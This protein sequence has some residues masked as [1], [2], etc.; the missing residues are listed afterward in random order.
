MANDLRLSMGVPILTAIRATATSSARR[1][2]IVFGLH[3]RLRLPFDPLRISPS[4]ILYLSTSWRKPSGKSSHAGPAWALT[5]GS[6]SRCARQA[7]FSPADT[8]HARAM[9]RWAMLLAARE[10]VSAR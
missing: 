4:P 10:V 3:G 5:G 7:G 8:F 1:V 6:V 2:L 9:E